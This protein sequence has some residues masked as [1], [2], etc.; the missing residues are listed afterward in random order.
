MSMS[1]IVSTHIDRWVSQILVANNQKDR[2]EHISSGKLSASMLGKPLQEQILKVKGVPP[3]EVDEYTLRKF[4]RG[5]D[6]E[7]WLVKNLPALIT[8]QKPVE[9]RNVVGLIDA[10]VSTSGWEKDFG[11]IPLEVK[12]VT[13]A[14]Y[15][16]IIRSGEAD[17]SHILQACLYA[18]AEN[19]PYFAICYIASDDYRITTMIFKTADYK[20]EVDSIIDKFEAQLAS[21][22]IPMFE[23]IEKW[24]ENKMYAAYPDWIDLTFEEVNKKYKELYGNSNH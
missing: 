21:E 5:K 16:N 12:S 15:K 22:M 18:L 9:Y 23:A 17:R 4:Q 24:Q 2:D 6:V 19:K 20:A 13:N 10:V 1:H 14:K 8:T 7:D 11:Q 3:K